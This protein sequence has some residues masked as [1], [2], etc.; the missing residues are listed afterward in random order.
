MGY[1][2]G[3]SMSRLRRG[4]KIMFLR[5]ARGRIRTP[6]GSY[7]HGPNFP[8]RTI[9][10]FLRISRERG[11]DVVVVDV[12]GIERHFRRDLEG[13]AWAS[14]HTPIMDNFI[15]DMV[16]SFKERKKKI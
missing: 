16:I 1:G 11:N 14:R 7:I 15:A 5:E 8:D 13:I 2:K 10:T 6:D 12:N 4:D 9:G 3:Q